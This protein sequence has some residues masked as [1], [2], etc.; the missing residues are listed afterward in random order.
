MLSYAPTTSDHLPSGRYFNV[1][2]SETTEKTNLQ[3]ISEADF[4]NQFPDAKK[5]QTTFLQ[6]IGAIPLVGP[7]IVLLKDA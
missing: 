4:L 2:L 5:L 6:P 3:I 1:S 7:L